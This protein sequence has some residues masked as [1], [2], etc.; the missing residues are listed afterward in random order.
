VYYLIILIIKLGK[1][2]VDAFIANYTYII[3]VLMILIIRKIYN[4]IMQIIV[5]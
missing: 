5:S 2:L 3:Y 1:L 4:E